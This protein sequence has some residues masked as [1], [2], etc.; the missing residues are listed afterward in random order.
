MAL[1]SR[2]TP[3]TSLA[4]IGAKQKGSEKRR[5]PHAPSTARISRN[6]VRTTEWRAERAKTNLAI[7]VG[8]GKRN[9]E[10]MSVCIRPVSRGRLTDLLNP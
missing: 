4:T 10:R 1:P 3:E 6:L 9:A 5:P 8:E 2:A 7:S